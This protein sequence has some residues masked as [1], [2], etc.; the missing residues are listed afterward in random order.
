MKL[1]RAIKCIAADLAYTFSDTSIKEKINADVYRY[2]K[3]NSRMKGKKDIHRL[4]YCLTSHKEFRNVFY[5]RIRRHPGYIAFSSLFLKKAEAVEINGEID[6]GLFISHM[7]A[8]VFPS[9]AGTNLRV[10]PGVV[11][12]KNR[13]KYPEIGNNVY[14]A[15]NS[16]VIGGI[17]I[18]DNVIIGAG[19]VVNKSLPGNGV[20]AGNP[21]RL[22][23]HID[24][25]TKYSEEIM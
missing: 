4:N 6:G 2:L 8:V 13:D 17:S 10:G 14:I 7:H 5:Y 15:A 9:K 1:T 22:I 23:R 3:W 25:D 21:V 16:T 18:G 24:E 20:Y 11:I 19:S 12:G